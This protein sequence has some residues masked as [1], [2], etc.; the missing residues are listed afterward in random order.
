M[1]DFQVE[2]WAKINRLAFFT[3]SVICL[4]HPLSPSLQVGKED[5]FYSFKEFFSLH[6]G[7]NKKAS[8][9]CHKPITFLFGFNTF[10][11]EVLKSGEK[12]VGLSRSTGNFKGYL[13]KILSLYLF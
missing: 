3:I 2:V 4:T 12:I 13:F 5:A 6:V 9:H 8:R 11:L 1:A 10:V 7:K